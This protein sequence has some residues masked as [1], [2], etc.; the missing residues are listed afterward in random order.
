MDV[1]DGFQITRGAVQ[2]QDGYLPMI[3][4]QGLSADGRTL[5]GA[6]PVTEYGVFDDQEEA[7][8]AGW[9]IRVRA[10]TVEDDGLSIRIDQ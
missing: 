9:T 1:V 2:V 8:N 7:I 5:R 6:V 4:A 10:I 3:E